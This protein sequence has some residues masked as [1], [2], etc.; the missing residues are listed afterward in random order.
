MAPVK[1]NAVGAVVAAAVVAARV[2]AK[3]V[4]TAPVKLRQVTNWR[5][6]MIQ[7]MNRPVKPPMNQPMKP[8]SA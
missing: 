6:V 7:R 1:M 8:A 2:I 4:K 5:T 3:R